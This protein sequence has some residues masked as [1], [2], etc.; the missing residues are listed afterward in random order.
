MQMYVVKIGNGIVYH[1]MAN[2]YENAAKKAISLPQAQLRCIVDAPITN[3]PVG[4]LNTSDVIVTSYN[5][6][7]GYQVCVA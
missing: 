5:K 7:K 4:L 1:I 2:S 6:V 3:V